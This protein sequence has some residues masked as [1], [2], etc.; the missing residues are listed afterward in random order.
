LNSKS[1]YA[2]LLLSSVLVVYAIVGG[3]LDRVAAQ[4]STLQQIDVFSQVYR[5][6]IDE[7]VDEPSASV[8]IAGAIRGLMSQ[9]D[10]YGGY[11]DAKDIAFY[12]SYNPEKTAGIGVVL[13]RVQIS[14]QVWYPVIVQVIPGSAAEKSGLRSLDIIEAI[15]GVATQEL[16]LVQ[17]H[18]FLANPPDKP[19]TLTLIGGLRAEPE[20]VVVN[21]EVTKVPPI[22]VEMRQG[23]I[24]YVRIPILAQ[25]KVS[26]ARRQLEDLL[27]KGATGI[28]LDLRS[29]AG[30]KDEEGFA[31]ANL[32]VESGTLGYLEGQ[33]FPRKL[34]AATPKNAVTKAPLVVLVNR[35]TGGPAELAAAAI[36]GTKRG[37]LV[38]TRTFGTGAFQNLIPLDAGHALLISV[39]KYYGPDG[40]E[41]QSNA[42]TP[43]IRIPE[44]DNRFEAEAPEAVE[45]PAPSP[46]KTDPSKTDEQRQMDKAIE[47]L[48]DL[49]SGK[50]A[51]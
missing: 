36:R 44:V 1:K 16:N 43:D 45:A 2:A 35:G 47:V 8:A 15:D 31:L 28:L 24:A 38:G 6:I 23:D 30:G 48:K 19:A 25:G 33:K 46:P 50:K 12:K 14:P 4:D 40:R 34:F 5:K 27:K 11:L 37:S 26:E 17:A 29:S 42:V 9:V 10:P 39:A 7:Y 32:F 18:G 21:R 22:Q 20:T 49:R 13:S 41:I 51:A 3:R